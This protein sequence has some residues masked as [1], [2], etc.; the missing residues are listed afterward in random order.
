MFALVESTVAGYNKFKAQQLE[1]PGEC[2]WSEVQFDNEYLTTVAPA[3]AHTVRDLDATTFV[4]R[5][6]T[7]LYDAIGKT[8][9]AIGKRLSE[10]PTTE[11]PS[12]VVVVITTDGAENC[13]KAY[14]ASKVQEMIEH[15][16]Q[17]YNW[18]FIF[19]GANQDAILTAGALGIGQA[20][21]LTYAPNSAGTEA[22]YASVSKAV[23]RSRTA[24][25]L[26]APA[27]A[28]FEEEDRTAQYQQ[29]A[30]DKLKN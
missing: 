14:S 11:R 18:E 8:I 1:A 10:T 3:P 16:Q 21:T 2:L 7:A 25:A 20:Q 19:M 6:P 30:T 13:S 12:K 28:A 15:Q 22:A 23:Y 24:T 9:D 27:A 4:P 29:G 26:N 5:G 17:K